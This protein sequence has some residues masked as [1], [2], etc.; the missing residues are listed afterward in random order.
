MIIYFV[1]GQFK[2]LIGIDFFFA[3]LSVSLCQ[4]G[5]LYQCY[6]P[7]R[8]ARFDSF[9]HLLYSFFFYRNPGLCGCAA[10]NGVILLVGRPKRG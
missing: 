7:P 3:F 5:V 2:K 6:V 1:G 8:T 9:T 10:K 4:H